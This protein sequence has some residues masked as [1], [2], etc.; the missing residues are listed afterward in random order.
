MLQHLGYPKSNRKSSD[1]VRQ[2]QLEELYE[3][4][5]E[6]QNYTK[7]KFFLKVVYSY[8]VPQ[9]IIKQSNG[10]LIT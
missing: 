1:E 5:L 2:T 10:Y 3:L 4:V 9:I 7:N 6:M 8:D